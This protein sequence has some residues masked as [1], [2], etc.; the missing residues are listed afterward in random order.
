MN[1]RPG[2]V[3]AVC[4]I[5]ILLGV[6]G[7]LGSL[8]N[9]ASL[10]L[11]SQGVRSMMPMPEQKEKVTRL[12]EE[13]QREIEAVTNPL[14]PLTI[15]LLVLEILASSGLIAAGVMTLGLKEQGRRL[16]RN[17]IALT[18]PLEIVR[19][20]LQAYFS[21]EIAEVMGKYMSQI[22]GAQAKGG[23]MPAE[24]GAS[25]AKMSMVFGIAWAAIC[26]VIALAFYITSWIYLNR[27]HVRA[28]FAAPTADDELA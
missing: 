16:L 12:Q 21:L 28:A 9:A 2:G 18:I 15:T 17:V 22:A 25:I 8:I 19:S 10:A 26:L 14:K 1:R 5:A 6:L 11:G 13:M 4:V 7:L 23:N 3:T 27:P 24:F 20:L